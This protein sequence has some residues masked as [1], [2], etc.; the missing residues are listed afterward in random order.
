MVPTSST[1]TT[2]TAL[3]NAL[4]V[5]PDDYSSIMQPYAR[6]KDACERTNDGW[7]TGGKSA[8]TR[9]CAT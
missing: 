7:I 9:T 1:S 5:E 4:T 3:K 6:S 2:P 8:S